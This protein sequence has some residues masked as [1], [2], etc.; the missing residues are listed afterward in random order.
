MKLLSLEQQ[1]NLI[2]GG[3]WIVGSL[4][5]ITFFDIIKISLDS[6]QIAQGTRGENRLFQE[7]N[8]NDDTIEIVHNNEILY[9]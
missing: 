8:N 2:G 4:I 3:A 7:L 6:Y 5:L 1:K 9:V